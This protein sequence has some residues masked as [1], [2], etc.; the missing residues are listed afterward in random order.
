ML[1]CYTKIDS[2]DLFWL[3][4]EFTRVR[5]DVHQRILFYPRDGT[6]ASWSNNTEGGSAALV[7][8]Q[9]QEAIV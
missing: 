4:T 1:R 8:T 7:L 6:I 5:S 3:D 2:V 9:K